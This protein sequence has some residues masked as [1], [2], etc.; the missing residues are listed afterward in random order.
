M[1]ERKM[2]LAYCVMPQKQGSQGR[3]EGRKEDEPSILCYDTKT[4]KSSD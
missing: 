1:K 4:R 2:S 3:K